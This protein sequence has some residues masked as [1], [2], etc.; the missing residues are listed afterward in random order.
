VAHLYPLYDNQTFLI[1][2]SA[3]VIKAVS[4]LPKCPLDVVPTQPGL[5]VVPI[6]HLGQD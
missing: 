6:C 4:T 2:I 1:K 5:D 3:Y